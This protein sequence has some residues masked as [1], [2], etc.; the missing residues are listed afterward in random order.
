VAATSLRLKSGDILFAGS[1]ETREDIGKCVAFIDDFQAYAG[2]DIVILRPK[3]MHSEFLGFYL[4]SEAIRN[5]KANLGQGDAVVHIYSHQ[6]SSIAIRIPEINE[7]QAIAE[8]LSNMD[9]E[10]TALEQR[11]EKTK[12][13]KQGMM[14]QLLTGRIRLVDPSTTKEANA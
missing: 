5:Q 14:Q 9:A 1:G 11:L 2:G 8:I 13:I 7:Q 12:A 4:N 3:D 10:I 6:L